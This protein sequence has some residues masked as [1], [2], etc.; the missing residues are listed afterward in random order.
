MTWCGGE[1]GQ[2]MNTWDVDSD[3]E[4]IVTDME[5]ISGLVSSI[6][7]RKLDPSHVNW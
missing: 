7:L 1:K 4:T 2:A 6:F 3:K 5:A